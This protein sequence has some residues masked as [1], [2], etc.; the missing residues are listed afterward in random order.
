MF[1]KL[2][3]LLI[4]GSLCFVTGAANAEPLMPMEIGTFWEYREYHESDPD[5][6]WTLRFEVLEEVTFDLDPG[7]GEDI[8]DYFHIGDES[9]GQVDGSFIRS[10]PD[11]VYESDGTS[12][13]MLWQTGSVETEWS[14]PDPTHPTRMPFGSMPFGSERFNGT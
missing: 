12:E 8:K 6:A 1:A 10:T 4:V 14:Y 13:V 9:P 3:S 7:L 2:R 5:N 11:A